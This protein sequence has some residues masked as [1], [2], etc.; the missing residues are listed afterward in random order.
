[1]ASARRRSQDRNCH[2][3]LLE[4]VHS[5][6]IPYRAVARLSSKTYCA[7]AAISVSRSRAPAIGGNRSGVLLRL[8]D[9]AADDAVDLRQRAGDLSPKHVARSGPSGVPLASLP[10]QLAQ[11][12]F[13]SKIA[14]PVACA[15]AEAGAPGATPA[16]GT[17]SSPRAG[18]MVSTR[19]DATATAASAARCNIAPA[20]LAANS[21]AAALSPGERHAS[22][23]ARLLPFEVPSRLAQQPH[24][25]VD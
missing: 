22:G 21:A 7:T 17:C 14:F 23:E 10:W 9:T 12:P 11:F 16:A 5:T 19:V 20:L 2:V 25:A 6:I 18:P 1:M 24:V 15:A 3:S 8:D 13:P 4:N